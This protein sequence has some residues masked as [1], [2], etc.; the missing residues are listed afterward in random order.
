MKTLVALSAFG[1]VLLAQAV[2][3][4]EPNGYLTLSAGHVAVFD[5]DVDKPAAL[6]IEYRLRSRWLWQLAPVVGAGASDA[7]ASFIY[8]AVDR[9]FHLGERWV[10]TP[11]F[12]MGSF[13]DGEDVKLGNELEFRSG[14]RFT[15][16]F[17]NDVRVGFGLFHLSNGGLS[18]RNPG[19]EPAFLSVHIP[20]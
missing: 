20:L 10:L 12:G 9:D 6:K 8:A 2:S 15:Y 19:T 7:G 18:D 4:Q 17:E 14:L 16:Q 11:T 1:S 5:N 13:D 3:A